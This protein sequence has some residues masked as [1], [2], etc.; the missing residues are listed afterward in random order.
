M[1]VPWALVPESS[2]PIQKWSTTTFWNRKTIWQDLSS[3]PSHLL[4]VALQSWCFKLDWCCRVLQY[5]V[6]RTVTKLHCHLNEAD[7]ATQW[8][9][10]SCPGFIWGAPFLLLSMKRIKLLQD[11][12]IC[13]PMAVKGSNMGLEERGRKTYHSQA[14]WKFGVEI[15]GLIHSIF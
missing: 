13:L 11:T 2:K 3:R 8:G 14:C 1:L 4:S 6:L 10:L 9:A 15:S 5:P 12:I 7:P